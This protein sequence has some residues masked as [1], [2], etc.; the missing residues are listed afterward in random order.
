MLSLRTNAQCLGLAGAVSVREEILGVPSNPTTSLRKAL[1]FIHRHRCRPKAP[2]FLQLT[3]PPQ[4]SGTMRL[5]W[6]DNSDNE[7]GFRVRFRGRREGFADD[8]GSKTVAASNSDLQQTTLSGL[9]QGFEY[10]LTV[11]AFNTAGE[12]EPSGAITRTIPLEEEDTRQVDL[13]REQVTMGFVPY[14]G[15]FPAGGVVNTGRLLKI[16]FPPVGPSDRL[17]LFPKRT[18]TTANCGVPGDV[19]VLE[20]G[21][22]LSGKDLEEIFGVIEPEFSTLSP[23][24]LIACLSSPGSAPPF[25]TVRLT[26]RVT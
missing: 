22:D 11:I 10:R 12:S 9:H 24:T 8:D 26:V 16:Q 17:L 7:D 21:G 13:Q 19:V 1:Q 3:E 20:E 4:A 18:K 23:L 15:L 5:S 14:R 6:S 25:V 2:S